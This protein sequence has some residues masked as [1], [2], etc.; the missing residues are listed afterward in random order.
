MHR[1]AKFTVVVTSPTPLLNK[2]YLPLYNVII[3]DFEK[4]KKAFLEVI[5]SAHAIFTR[6]R[7]QIDKEVIDAGRN[8]KV[9]ARH[10]VGYDNVD[11]KYAASKGIWV[12]NTPDVVS[13]ATAEIAFAHMLN[14]SRKFSDSERWMRQGNFLGSFER[15]MGVDLCGKILGILGMGGIGKILANR[16]AAFEMKIIYH[17]R[18]PLN[19]QEEKQCGNAQYVTKDYLLKTSDFISMNIPSSKDTIHY[20]NKPEFDMMK[21]GVYIINTARGSLINENAL[22]EAIE[23]GK[24]R[25]A[26]LDV[27]ENEPDVNPKLYTLP[28]VSLTPHIGAATA[29]TRKAIEDLTWKNIHEVLTGTGIPPNPVQ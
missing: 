13:R 4:N 1:L 3:G 17:N 25:G 28:N 23:S 14:I 9:I 11:A 16:A 15:F 21:N 5:P 26:G 24:V 7:I 8:L 10:G 29:E 22:I 2:D 20:L 18:N 6:P 12:T 19:S 27:F